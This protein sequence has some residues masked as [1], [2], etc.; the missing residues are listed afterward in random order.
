MTRWKPH[1][2]T[3]KLEA[4]LARIEARRAVRKHSP[5]IEY[6]DRADVPALIA[7]RVAQGRIAPQAGVLVVPEDAPDMETWERR[8]ASGCYRNSKL[9]VSDCAV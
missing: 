4:K 8:V 6:R 5:V 2:V 7:E 3:T 1:T 9:T